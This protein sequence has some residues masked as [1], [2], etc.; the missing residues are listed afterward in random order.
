VINSD[1]ALIQSWFI[2]IKFLSMEVLIVLYECLYA[3]LINRSEKRLH[4]Q[5]SAKI[6]TKPV[7]LYDTLS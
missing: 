5:S 3:K 7:E 1:H 2:A 6:C 4:S